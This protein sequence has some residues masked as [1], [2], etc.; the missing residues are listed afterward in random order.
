MDTYIYFPGFI[1]FQNQTEDFLTGASTQA[2]VEG[3]LIIG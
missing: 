1:F 3:E 2:Q